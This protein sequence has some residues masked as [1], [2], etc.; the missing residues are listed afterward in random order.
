MLDSNGPITTRID[1][2]TGVEYF[3]RLLTPE[4]V[5][6]RKCIRGFHGNTFFYHLALSDQG[7]SRRNSSRQRLESI[8]SVVS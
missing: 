1:F 8:S 7:S 6:V 2:D 5:D 3:Q 4:S